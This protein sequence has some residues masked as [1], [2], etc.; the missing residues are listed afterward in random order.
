MDVKKK[1][2]QM[3]PKPNGQRKR[4]DSSCICINRSR[5]T[6][7]TEGGRK[8]P[9]YKLH[10]NGTPWFGL[11]WGIAFSFV[12]MSSVLTLSNDQSCFQ[13]WMHFPIYST[14]VCFLFVAVDNSLAFYGL[15]V[16]GQPRTLDWIYGLER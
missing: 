10:Q 7:E 11:S 6:K 1:I 16:P 4:N 13:S 5:K 12:L 3:H 9:N 14:L 8:K 15:S 2:V